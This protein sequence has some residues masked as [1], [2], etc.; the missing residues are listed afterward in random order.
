MNRWGRGY[1]NLQ[2][3]VHDSVHELTGT[4][5]PGN[6]NLRHSRWSYLIGPLYLFSLV[7]F[8]LPGDLLS[9]YTRF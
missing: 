6:V 2:G 9:G 1:V 4:F 3:K 7:L 5:S 8:S